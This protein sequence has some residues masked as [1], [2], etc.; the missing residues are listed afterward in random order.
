MEEP[1]KSN[2][3]NP[4]HILLTIVGLG[5][6][7]CALGCVGAGDYREAFYGFFPGLALLA[8][9]VM[10]GFFG[11]FFGGVVSLALLWMTPTRVQRLTG[12]VALALAAA[13]TVGAYFYAERRDAQWLAEYREKAGFNVPL[14]PGEDFQLRAEI[15]GEDTQ[16]PVPWIEIDGRDWSLRYVHRDPLRGVPR[17]QECVGKPVAQDL[18]RLLEALAAVSTRIE[19]NEPLCAGSEDSVVT[20]SVVYSGQG[21]D[22]ALEAGPNCLQPDGTREETVHGLEMA[23]DFLAPVEDDERISCTDA[24]PGGAT[25]G[26]F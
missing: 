21:G 9:M 8:T 5:W 3:V 13:S 22:W 25:P 19:R 12:L 10:W 14:P 6:T 23:L 2:R 7:G 18:G 20:L 4:I 17:T 16:P 11:A 1:Q 26:A 24:V 15:R